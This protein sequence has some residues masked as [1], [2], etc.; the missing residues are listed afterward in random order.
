VL[1]LRGQDLK[2]DEAV[3]I[4][5]EPG[6]KGRGKV[7]YVPVSSD[8]YTCLRTLSVVNEGGRLFPFGRTTI[9]EWWA[10]LCKKAGITGVTLH[11]LRATYITM[12]LDAGVSPIEVTKLVGHSSLRMTMRYYRN[13][14]E[15]REAARHIREALGIRETPEAVEEAQR[16][17]QQLSQRAS[18]ER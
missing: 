9:R 7:R 3:V 8:L 13:T 17:S 11:G 15:S 1:N 6:S 16:S 5:S 10:E 2:D 12:A 14:Q 4:R 18:A